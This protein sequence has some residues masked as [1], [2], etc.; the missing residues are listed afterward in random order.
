MI[1]KI[2]TVFAIVINGIVANN[3]NAQ[4]FVNGSFENTTSSGCA[5]NLYNSDFNL[6]MAGCH[7]Y[8][9]NEELD[10]QTGICYGT[11]IN[12]NTFVSL[13]VEMNTLLKD[14][15]TMSLTQPL[16]AG[17]TY[18]LT[19]YLMANTQFG[20]GTIDSLEVGISANDSTFGQ[21]LGAFWQTTSGWTPASITFVAPANVN[22]ISLQNQ[23]NQYGWVFVDDFVLTDLSAIN[24][25]EQS[26]PSVVFN[27]KSNMLQVSSS[28]QLKYISVADASGRIISVHMAQGFKFYQ[29]LPRLSGGIYFVTAVFAD[30]DAFKTKIIK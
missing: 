11:A 14:G 6:Y 30:G 18:H 9:P 20:T 16:T 21:K 3:I 12:G 17:N 2:L 28:R 23:A 10:I 29:M 15:F 4:S 5:Y 19:F 7:A 1:K 24:S 8:G 25:I 26:N 22:Y 27:Q 13:A